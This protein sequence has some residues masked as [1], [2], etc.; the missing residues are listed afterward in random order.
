MTVFIR[1]LLVAD[2]GFRLPCSGT[3]LMRFGILALLRRYGPPAYVRLRGIFGGL[4]LRYYLG[5]MLLE[6]MR[7]LGCVS[8]CTFGTAGR[9]G[10]LE[11]GLGYCDRASRFRLLYL[12]VGGHAVG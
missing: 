5:S 1:G 8:R 7:V 11:Q 10:R 3:W 6:I 9:S 4:G 12:L 2:M